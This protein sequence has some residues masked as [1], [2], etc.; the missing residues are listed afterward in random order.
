MP[1]YFVLEAIHT[2]EKKTGLES[3]RHISLVKEVPYF[4]I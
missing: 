1:G 3:D 2:E 4:F